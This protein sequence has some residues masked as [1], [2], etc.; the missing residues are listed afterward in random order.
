MFDL[1]TTQKFAQRILLQ[2]LI[3]NEDMQMLQN[4]VRNLGSFLGYILQ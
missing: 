4:L 2:F 3:D 1:N